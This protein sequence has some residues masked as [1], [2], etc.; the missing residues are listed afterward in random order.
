MIEVIVSPGKL[1]TSNAIMEWLAAVGI[2]SASARR[3]HDDP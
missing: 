2:R 1:S 3:V